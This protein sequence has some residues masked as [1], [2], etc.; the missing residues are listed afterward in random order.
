M[1]FISDN[2]GWLFIGGIILFG[3]LSSL[4]EN[5]GTRKT[6]TTYHATSVTSPRPST[7]SSA[8]SATSMGYAPSKGLSA[9]ENI[10]ENKIK[11]G[12]TIQVR[13]IKQNG[14]VTNRTLKPLYTKHENGCMYLRA[15]CYLRREERTF[16]LSRMEI[17]S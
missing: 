17:L 4:F 7:S 14:A 9:K 11:S 6:S 8:G 5:K 12:G 15:Y 1:E 13:Y 16:R 3:I 10:I 2:I